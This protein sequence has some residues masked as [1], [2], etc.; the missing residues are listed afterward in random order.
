MNARLKLNSA[1]FQGALII[2][3]LIGWA[4]GS[5]LAFVL[6]AAAII[7][8]AYHSGDIRTTPSKPKPPVQPTHQIRAMHR[9][10]R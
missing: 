4:F 9:R 8:T 3:G 7:L 10:R 1:V 2:G 5:W 6:A